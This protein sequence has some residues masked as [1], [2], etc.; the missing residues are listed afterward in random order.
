M[1][2]LSIPPSYR[3]TGNVPDRV[4]AKN[5]RTQ[6]GNSVL[7][8]STV[9]CHGLCTRNKVLYT[10]RFWRLCFKRD[11]NPKLRQRAETTTTYVDVDSLQ[12]VIPTWGLFLFR[13]LVH[14]FAGSQRRSFGGIITIQQPGCIPHKQYP[15]ETVKSQRNTSSYARLPGIILLFDQTGPI[16]TGQ[17]GPRKDRKEQNLTDGRKVFTFYVRGLLRARARRLLYTFKLLVVQP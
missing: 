14:I 1:M 10:A 12:E 9:C 3:C 17:G 13:L 6:M 5:D 4:H 11:A 16:L 7:S 15:I 8:A 2:P